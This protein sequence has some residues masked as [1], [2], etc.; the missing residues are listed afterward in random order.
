M[1]TV[2]HVRGRV[3][4]D[5]LKLTWLNARQR[6]VAT[7]VAEALLAAVQS[8]I[9]ATR[10]AVDEALD[11]VAGDQGPARLMAGL[12]KLVL[13]RCVFEV[14]EP[15]F[16]AELRGVLFAKA[17]ETWR[18]LGDPAAFDR[19]AVLAAVAGEFSLDV[20]DFESRLY[21]D[22]REAQRL[23]QVRAV[24]ADALV[25]GYDLAQLQAAILRADWL[26]VEFSAPPSQEMR[27]LLAQ[28]K[29]RRLLF[30]LRVPRPGCYSL[31]IDGPLSLFRQGNK[32]G[33]ALALFLPEL[34]RAPGWRLQAQLRWGR[35][36]RIV[37]LQV[38]DGDLP[39]PVYRKPARPQVA[40]ELQRLLRDIEGIKGPWQ[41]QL[42]HTL[43]SLP[44]G[45]T[46]LPDLCLEHRPSRFVVYLEALGFWHRD[47]VWQ[48]LQWAEA[49]L[50]APVLWLASKRLRV[51]EALFA[52]EREARLLLYAERIPVKK[53]LACCEALRLMASS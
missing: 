41:A 49:G 20:A 34:V 11:G 22:L 40:D 21:A 5:S 29:F 35:D 50:P 42:S 10:A 6:R 28:L 16:G 44:Q 9:G 2:D 8:H 15:P 53:V 25:Q 43:W 47:A 17:T 4:E 45:Q 31:H 14:P 13:D 18:N 19:A 48:R 26:R 23:T 32:Y 39:W 3:Q 30:L 24:Q 12:R 37:Q 27:Q 52:A 36:K 51:S 46:M 1:L 7:E 38:Q 33:L